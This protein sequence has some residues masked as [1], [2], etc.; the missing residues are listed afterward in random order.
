MKG[1][2]LLTVVVLGWISLPVMAATIGDPETLGQ[3]KASV[4]LEGEYI[5]D[6]EFESFDENFT[7]GLGTVTAP[8]EAEFDGFYRGFLKLGYGIMDWLDFYKG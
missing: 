5:I 2:L 3:G 7:S 4:G 8:V 6:M 1:K